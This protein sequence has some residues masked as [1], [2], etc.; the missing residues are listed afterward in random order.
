MDLVLLALAGALGALCR[1]GTYRWFLTFTDPGFP[2]ATVAVNCAGSF[3]FG[4]VVVLAEE[5]E[6]ISARTKIVVLVGFLGAFTT[7][8]TFAFE[9]V[10]LMR[11]GDTAR[12][13]FNAA[14]QNLGAVGCVVLGATTAR[15]LAG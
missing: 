8:S 4:A 7:F 10:E 1:Y 5:Q 9:T 14:L 15:M 3:L 11:V 2:W 13:L 6:L 12:A